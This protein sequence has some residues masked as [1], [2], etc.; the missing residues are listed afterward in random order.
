MP[1]SHVCVLTIVLVCLSSH[2]TAARADNVQT[3]QPALEQTAAFSWEHRLSGKVVSLKGTMLEI[4]T[5]DKR[6]VA[7]DA[8]PAI[9]SHR[10]YVLA[11]GA[12]ITAFGSYDQKGVL[13]AKGV[14][15]AK[16]LPAAWPEDR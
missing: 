10:A 11:V 6:T 9:D 3:S 16:R 13:H 2:P 7:V 5:R 12:L 1:A 14:T 8:A 4:E 15:R